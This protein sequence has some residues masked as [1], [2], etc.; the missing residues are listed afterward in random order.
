MLRTVDHCMPEPLATIVPGD[1]GRQNVRRRH[2]QA[3]AVRRA[4]RRRRDDFRRRALAVGQVG[5]ADLFADGDDDALPADHRAETERDRHAD[6]DPERNEL[7]RAIELLLEGAD[8]RLVRGRQLALLVLRQDAETLRGEIHVVTKVLD[9]VER[10]LG[11]GAILLDRVADLLG[12]DRERRIGALR[13]RVGMNVF[14]HRRAGIA[15]DGVSG[16]MGFDDLRSGVR[17]GNELRRRD[18][19]PARG[20]AHRPSARRRSGS[21]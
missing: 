1:A 13:D 12:Q 7:G 16:A 18:L 6:L 10:R 15:G 8:L 2:R 20:S 11:D 5:L 19:R 14:R 4:D 17:G 3:E 21:A 9:L